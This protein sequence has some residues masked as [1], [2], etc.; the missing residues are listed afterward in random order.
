MVVYLPI[1]LRLD[2]LASA[3][4]RWMPEVDD[5]AVESSSETRGDPGIIH[6]VAE[7]NGGVAVPYG[8]PHH[9]NGTAAVRR[10]LDEL[11]AEVGSEVLASLVEMFLADAMSRI[12]KLHR[13]LADQDARG[14]HETAHA[15]KGSCLNLGADDMA[16]LCSEIEDLGEERRLGEVAALLARVELEYESVRAELEAVAPA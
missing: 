2:D 4:E 8:P 15:L 10:R 11:R 6:L 9:E 12:E 1:P 7:I 16:R 3:I 14:V 13:E 5:D